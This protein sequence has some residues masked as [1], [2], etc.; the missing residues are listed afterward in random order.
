VDEVFLV[1]IKK[2]F[3]FA[4]IFKSCIYNHFFTNF[5]M[6]MFKNLHL[7][8]IMFYEGFRIQASHLHLL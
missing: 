4:C 6:W 2:Y 3:I 8:V 1:M 7:K 5:N